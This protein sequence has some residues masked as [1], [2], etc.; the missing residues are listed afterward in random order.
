MPND[1]QPDNV[2]GDPDP[3]CQIEPGIVTIVQGVQKI[4]DVYVSGPTKVSIDAAF[5]LLVVALQ[6]PCT[7][8]ALGSGGR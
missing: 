7:N 5:A 2:P 3:Y 1:N 4:V 6:A 8:S